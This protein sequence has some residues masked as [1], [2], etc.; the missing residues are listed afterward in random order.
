MKI[1]LF[2]VVV[3][4]VANNYCYGIENNYE[5]VS[6]DQDTKVIAQSYY[7]AMAEKNF[8]GVAQYLDKDVIFV[9]P[10]ITIIGKSAFL[11]RVTDFFAYS[12]ILTIRTVFGSHDQAVVV[13]TLDYPA[14]IGR[15]ETAALLNIQDGLITKIELF[16]DGRL[17]EKKNK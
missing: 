14:P 17:F 8:D 2:M 9:A 11:E 1:T 7:T 3:V 6:I 16:Y 10:L 15:V 13:F 4:L 12:A 5:I